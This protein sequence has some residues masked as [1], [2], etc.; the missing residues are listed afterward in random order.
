MAGDQPMWGN[1]RAVAPTPAS[2]IVPVELGDNFNIKG[3]SLS[4]IKDRQFD[5]RGRAD[6]HKH[7]AKFIKIYGMFRYGNTNVDSIK[8]KLFPSSLNG[9]SKSLVQQIESWCY[10]YLGRDETSFSNDK[11]YRPLLARNEHANAV[12]TRSGKSYDLPVN[13]NDKPTLIHDDSDD[14]DDEAERKE[15]PFSSKP[16]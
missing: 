10:H 9:R 8:L 3:H 6:P 14:E 1:N 11:P 4:M 12:F 15:E 5:G 2:A 7:I 16:T 13:P